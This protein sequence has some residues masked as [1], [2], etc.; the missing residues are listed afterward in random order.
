MPRPKGSF[1]LTIYQENEIID[2]YCNNNLS[3]TK[4]SKLLK[5]SHTTVGKILKKYN[6]IMRTPSE[7]MKLAGTIFPGRPL[8]LTKCQEQE[9]IM[10][11]CQDK[12]SANKI[13]KLLSV[14]GS[15]IENILH[16][17]NILVR[18][19]SETNK[20]STKFSFREMNE[21]KAFLLGVI[22]G[23]GSISIRQDYINI[24]SGDL[25][26]LEKCQKILG[27]KF[28]I[29]KV[30]DSNCY[31]GVIYSHKLCEELLELFKLTNNK[32]DKLVF[33]QLDNKFMPAFISG[34]LATDGC[35]RMNSSKKTQCKSLHITFYSCSKQYLLDLQKYINNDINALGL[36]YERKNI[37]GHLGKKPLFILTFNGKKAEQLAI[38]IMRNT[39]ISIQCN[40]KTNK[41]KTYMLAKYNIIL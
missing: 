40:R 2:Y 9:A 10:L 5:I 11:Y 30:K 14:S 27:E 32:S 23:D 35:I 36:L 1:K 34:Y 29:A 22:Y 20:L 26:I 7:T 39:T 18:T 25:D 4:I 15:T 12:L 31:R 38:Y 8:I 33:P 6:I 19:S 41:Y 37:K 17:Y 24:T 3:T 28:K 16:K 21:G 13:G